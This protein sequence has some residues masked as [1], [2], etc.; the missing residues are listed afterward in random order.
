M[1]ISIKDNNFLFLDKNSKTTKITNYYTY[2]KVNKYDPINIFLYFQAIKKR[3][4]KLNK[5]EFEAIKNEMYDIRFDINITNYAT[6][7]LISKTVDFIHPYLSKVDVVKNNDLISDFMDNNTYE[8][9]D[10]LN[11]AKD[12]KMELLSLKDDYIAYSQRISSDIIYKHDDTYLTYEEELNYLN[13]LSDEEINI[14]I[15]FCNTIIRSNSEDFTFSSS[16]RHNLTRFKPVLSETTDIITLDIDQANHFIYYQ[17]SEVSDYVLKLYSGVIGGFATSRLFSEVRE[18]NSL[19]Y[20]IYSRPVGNDKMFIHC[21]MKY[22]NIKKADEIISELLKVEITQAELDE[23]KK[24]IISFYNKKRNDYFM[25]KKL[26]EDY[27]FEDK[28]YDYNVVIKELNNV[29]L[30]DVN[31]LHKTIQKQNIITIK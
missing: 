18:K 13:N 7:I 4:K 20:F 25:N 24:Q 1:Q 21:G 5:L 23:A 28:E 14:E 9:S 31:N 19:C 16:E 29:T 6:D 22:E 30:K 2:K 3:T 8:V 11:A 15:D 27:L 17:L 12:Y 26:V 10:F